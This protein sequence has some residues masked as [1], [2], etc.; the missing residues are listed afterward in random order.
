[1]KRDIARIQYYF[2]ITLPEV[3]LDLPIEFQ[4]NQTWQFYGLAR[5][6]G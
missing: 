6:L 1:M 5:I 3:F 4:A 2:P